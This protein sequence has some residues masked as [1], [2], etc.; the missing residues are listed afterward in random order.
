MYRHSQYMYINLET[1]GKMLSQ[2]QYNTNAVFHIKS[3]WMHKTNKKWQSITYSYLQKNMC[4]RHCNILFQNKKSAPGITII[5]IN[6]SDVKLRP[7]RWHL[8]FTVMWFGKID[9]PFFLFFIIFI[10]LELSIKNQFEVHSFNSISRWRAGREADQNRQIWLF[11]YC[12]LLYGFNVSFIT[13]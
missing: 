6:K 1:F 9:E 7:W 2:T 10:L 5:D 13:N 12:C 8:W 4:K 3:K 11:V